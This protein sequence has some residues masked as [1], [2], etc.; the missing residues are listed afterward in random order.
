MKNINNK[1]IKE[2]VEMY[3]EGVKSV[4]IAYNKNNNLSIYEPHQVDY[5]E[6]S[7]QV[8]ILNLEIYNTYEDI[9]KEIIYMLES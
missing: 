3:Q 8:G 6:K 7:Y 4:L 1:I 2:L 9:K 5:I